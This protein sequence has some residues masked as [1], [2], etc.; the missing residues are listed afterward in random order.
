[1]GWAAV[2]VGTTTLCLESQTLCCFLHLTDFSSYCYIRTDVVCWWLSHMSK[3]QLCSAELF[4]CSGSV[5]SN[6]GGVTQ[7]ASMH[8]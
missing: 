6:G 1:M 2:A 5:G 4:A 7:F 3:V 8:L